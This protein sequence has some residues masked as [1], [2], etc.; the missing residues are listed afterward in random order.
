MSSYHFGRIFYCLN[1]SVC[2][3][4][5]DHFV[6]VFAADGAGVADLLLLEG[7]AAGGNSGNF[8]ELVFAGAVAAPHGFDKSAFGVG[9]LDEFV[10]IVCGIGA[11]LA[12]FEG[13]FVQTVAYGF[14]QL[15]NLGFKLVKGDEIFLSVVAADKNALVLSYIAGT[16]FLT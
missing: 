5:I 4:P 16:Y 1:L 12:V 14:E 15:R 10:E 3:A 13:A 11:A 2:F 7:D 8:L 6:G 9:K